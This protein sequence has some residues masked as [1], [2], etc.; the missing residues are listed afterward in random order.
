MTT[1]AKEIQ[2]RGDSILQLPFVPPRSLY[3]AKLG[4]LNDVDVSADTDGNVLTVQPDGSFALE[5][6]SGGG[7]ASAWG[8][9]T[10]TLSSQTD[11]QAALNGKAAT[12]H[13]HATSDVTGLDAALTARALTTRTI[14]AGTGLTGGGSLA[15]DR[16]FAVSFGTTGTTVCVGNDARLSDAR[17]PTTHSHPTSQ[18]TGLD[19]ALAARISGSTGATDNRLLRSDGTGGATAQASGI[20]VD[21]S[22]NVSGV[23]TFASGA[24]TCSA[25]ISGT[26]G[27][28]TGVVT[29][30]NGATSSRINVDSN[31][32]GGNSRTIRFVPIDD[33]STNTIAMDLLS[34]SSS[35]ILPA[36]RLFSSN[37]SGTTQAFTI[38]TASSGMDSVNWHFAAT[39]VGSANANSL[40]IDFWVS[41]TTDGRFCALLVGINGVVNPSRGVQ[42]PTE[43]T[44]TPTG[45]TQTI[46]LNAG[47]HQTLSLVSATGTVTATL[48]VPTGASCSGTILIRQHATTP[49]GITWA[50]SA[51]SIKWLGTQPAWSSD[52][53]NSYRVVSWRWNGSFMFLSASASGT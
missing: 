3:G 25:G 48:T 12:S 50:V 39:V 6:P 38:G 44:A 46:F 29:I 32:S 45:T 11:L 49:R 21:D 23:G 20:T 41:N 43:V 17:T 7:G 28:F 14:S 30:G 36:Y 8:G 53:V 26:T 31:L 18:V 13:S 15:A 10:G 37:V 52:A 27:V 42:W 4:D 35:T 1:P 16:T 19:A 22:N 51:G 33:T 2:L 9:I 34:G 47:N 40:P 5:T 24:I